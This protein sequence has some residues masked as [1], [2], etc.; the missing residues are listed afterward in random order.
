MV[1][2]SLGCFVVVDLVGLRNRA[3]TIVAG[4]NILILP[5]SSLV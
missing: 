2:S 4:A 1:W 3:A 5:S